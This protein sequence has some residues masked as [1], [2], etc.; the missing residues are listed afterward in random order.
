M[1]RG[2]SGTVPGAAVVVRG[3]PCCCRVGSGLTMFFD[4]PSSVEGPSKHVHPGSPRIE[5]SLGPGLSGMV[6]V[7]SGFG[8]TWA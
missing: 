6:R 8:V 7:G 1:V 3:H 2:R 4:R 5:A